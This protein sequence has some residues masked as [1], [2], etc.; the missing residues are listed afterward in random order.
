VARIKFQPNNIGAVI[1]RYAQIIGIKHS[2][3][4]KRH[5]MEFRFRTLD[6][7]PFVLDDPI[8]GTLG[9]SDETYDDITV[10]YDD[11]NIDYDGIVTSGNRLG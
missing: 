4:S 8:F 3:D 5:K 1:D 11:A 10:F 7:A 6:Y 9:G 2:V